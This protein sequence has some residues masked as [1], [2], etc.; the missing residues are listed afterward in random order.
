MKIHTFYCSHCNRIKSYMSDTTPGYALTAD[1]EKYCYDCCAI[2]DRE[3]M[4]EHGHSKG[5]PLYLTY[6]R[7]S[8]SEYF[9]NPIITNWPGTLKFTAF[10]PNML[11]RRGRHNIAG[12]RYD[13]WFA[14]PDGYV[15]H[16][17]KYGEFTQICH[18]KRTKEKIK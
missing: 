11:R 13:V 3:Y 10:N 14:G 4:I 17:V 15:W 2:A 16:G 18:C 5:L 8:N 1:G 6:E 12:T 7:G 9:K